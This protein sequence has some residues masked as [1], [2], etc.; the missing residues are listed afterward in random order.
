MVTVYSH[1][2]F[3]ALEEVNNPITY[4]QVDT[5]KR[6]LMRLSDMISA[7]SS[8]PKPVL[9]A[10]L[11][12]I[13]EIS[14]FPSSFLQSTNIVDILGGLILS[15][16]DELT[17][18]GIRT[19]AAFAQHSEDFTHE[20]IE[21]EPTETLGKVAAHG[22]IRIRKQTVDLFHALCATESGRKYM[23]RGANVWVA[24]P[25]KMLN[26]FLNEPREAPD[27]ANALGKYTDLVKLAKLI[28]GMEKLGEEYVRIAET[29][30]TTVYAV[31]LAPIVINL[32]RFV[33]DSWP[34]AV[35]GKRVV[36]VILG[37]LHNEKYISS[38]PEIL[39]FIAQWLKSSDDAI[40]DIGES[41]I[42]KC[43]EIFKEHHQSAEIRMPALDVFTNVSVFAS[44]CVQWL[45]GDG[46]LLP[47]FVE[48]WTNEDSETQ[49]NV[50]WTIWSMLYTATIEQIMYI[51]PITCELLME[52]W[53]SDDTRFLVTA[54]ESL[55]MIFKRLFKSGMWND[56]QV[57]IFIQSML[58]SVEETMAENSSKEIL[59]L[60]SQILEFRKVLSKN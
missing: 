51:L 42:E 30:L 45:I 5:K 39:K 22:D 54:L 48:L 25:M 52:T 24:M 33:A 29:A 17:F 23:L 59:R 14:D 38:V 28:G 13:P 43:L 53:M 58:Q 19:V 60:S 1:M 27:C 49:Q 16:D 34:E 50:I 32:V 47:I 26:R 11:E 46:S 10:M 31:D 18:L 56:A 36:R 2:N 41:T 9:R 7:L 40:D 57:L 55:N 44:D 4:L 8:D 21:K 6:R 20:L 35:A 15:G 37:M 3:H 12:F